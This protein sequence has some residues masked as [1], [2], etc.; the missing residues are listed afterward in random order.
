MVDNGRFTI[1]YDNNQ[2]VNIFICTT[3]GWVRLF[4]KEEHMHKYQDLIENKRAEKISEF[5][6]L[7]HDEQNSFL[8]YTL[9]YYFDDINW[10]VDAIPNKFDAKW[11][12][13]PDWPTI[14][15][16]FL[17]SLYDRIQLDPNFD[18][19]PILIFFISHNV[20]V[21][22][23]DNLAI[24]IVSEF[25]CPSLLRLLIKYGA[26]IFV[27]NNYPICVASLYHA[28]ENVQFLV[29]VGADI[30]ACNGYPFCTFF[31]RQQQFHG[32]I[33][34]AQECKD[35]MIDYFLN[36][37]IDPNISSGYAIRACVIEGDLHLFDK[38]VTYG[39]NVSYICIEELVY[40]IRYHNSDFI[41]KLVNYGV[42]FSK[43][44]AYDIKKDIMSKINL[45]LSTGVDTNCLIALIMDKN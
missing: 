39:A 45:L 6:N 21:S 37:N 17:C 38:I 24:K 42:D 5:M 19:E 44:N 11:P 4:S 28:Y 18:T 23:H 14:F 31:A 36:N 32:R 33:G 15:I 12:N 7:L 1:F 35:K 8:A 34:I 20:D 43:I 9:L 40:V 27:D 41:N 29:S 26:N 2:K 30:A 25:N 16:F 3:D 10:I 13:I 22:I